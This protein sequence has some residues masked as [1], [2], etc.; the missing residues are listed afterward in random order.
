MKK[1]LSER[2]TNVEDNFTERKLEGANRKDFRETL[3]AFANTV[4]AGKTGVLFIGVTDKGAVRGVQEPDSIQK[5]IAKIC[6]RDCYPPIT[7]RSEVLTKNGKHVVAVE[8]EES[9]DKPHFSGPA[10]VRTGS[11]NVIASPEL[12]QKM[13]EYRNSKV[14]TIRNWRNRILTVETADKVLG[15]P[16][17]THSPHRTRHE[18][19]VKECTSDFIRLLDIHKN[20]Y[21]SE[22]LENVQISW[23]ESKDRLKLIIK[24]KS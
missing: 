11:K 3:V 7:F 13:I 5:T 18:C 4:P 16:G 22:P 23:D 14:Y 6:S 17:R 19:Q 24:E 20:V 12:F 10:Y 8:V 2:L 1:S 15:F 21:S 9:R